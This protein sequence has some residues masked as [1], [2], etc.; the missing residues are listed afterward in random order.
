M[1]MGFLKCFLLGNSL[2]SGIR[3]EHGES[4]KSR[5]EYVYIS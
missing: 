4:L 5:L 1:F 2:A 3:E